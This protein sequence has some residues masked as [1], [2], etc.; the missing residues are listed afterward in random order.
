MARSRYSSSRIID[1]HYGTW[2]NPVA[3]RLD[4]D[5]LEGVA[6]FSYTMAAG[7][8]LDHLA[9]RYLGDDRYYWVIALVNNIIYPLGIAPGTVLH[10]PKNV[11]DVLNKLQR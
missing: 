5:I 9:A 4:G 6:T 10:I 3:E 11:V 2:R 7:D 8:R 1:G